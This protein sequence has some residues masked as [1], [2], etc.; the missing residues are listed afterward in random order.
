LPRSSV[1]RANIVRKIFID[2]NPTPADL[3]AGDESV[4]GLLAQRLGVHPQEGRRFIQV[5]GFHGVPLSVRH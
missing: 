2:K 4:L 5:Q 3:R 1:L